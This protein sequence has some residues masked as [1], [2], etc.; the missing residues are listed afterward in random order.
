MKKIQ[1]LSVLVTILLFFF[2]NKISAQHRPDMAT[3]KQQM[4]RAQYMID[5]AKKANPEIQAALNKYGKMQ[6]DVQNQLDSFHKANPKNIDKVKMPTADELTK[7]TPLPDF[8]KIAKITETSNAQI[9]KY[10]ALTAQN[11]TEGLPKP[12]AGNNFTAIPD[13]DNN[14]IVAIAT[15]MQKVC[16]DSLNRINPYF[17]QALDT[18]ALDTTSTTAAKGMLMI[19]EG[20]SKFASKYL[21]CKG[22]VENHNNPW[23]IND[24]GT[25]LRNDN[26]LPE[27]IRCFKY[28]F[29]FNDTFQIIKC[30]MAWATAYYGDF[31]NA[32]KMFREIVQRI[33]SF[34]LA[35]EGLGMVAYKQGDLATVWECMKAQLKTF[36]GGDNSGPS[37][38][39]TSICDNVMQEQ[40]MKK[41]DGQG[42]QTSPMNDNTFTNDNGEGDDN[43][44]PPPTADSE[45][46]IYEESLGGMFAQNIDQMQPIN[47]QLKSF[48]DKILGKIKSAKD[49]VTEAQK[50]LSR[51]EPPAYTTDQGE[52]ITPHSF[53]KLNV[54][55]HIVQKQYSQRISWIHKGFEKEW[56]DLENSLTAQRIAFDENSTKAL[57]KCRSDQ[58]V[59]DFY[60]IWG[61]KAKGF[62]GQN[63]MGVS[64]LWSDYFKKVTNTSDWYVS[65][66]T[67]FIKRM[68]KQ[69]WNKYLNA[70]REDD[71]RNSILGF[72][73]KWLPMQ[74]LATDGIAVQIMSVEVSCQTEIREIPANGPDPKMV[75]LKKL[76]TAAPYCDRKAPGTSIDAVLF[77]YEDNCDH[78]K[79][80]F[81]PPHPFKF[82]STIGA[83][84]VK[85][86]VKVGVDIGFA[87]EEVK[88]PKFSDKNYYKAGIIIGVG[89]EASG[90]FKVGNGVSNMG[91]EGKMGALATIEFGSRYNQDLSKQGNYSAVSLS[92]GISGKLNL[93]GIK[94][95][96][97]S[98]SEYKKE[99]YTGQSSNYKVMSDGVTNTIKNGLQ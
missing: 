25:F 57:S 51:L 38:E 65:A 72:Y 98:K 44:D 6:P 61:P 91:G 84:P 97:S 31:I 35:W 33:P 28:A 13:A 83:G 52:T 92:E 37:D 10:R 67:P 48:Y 95:E 74:G 50:G 90:S 89:A 64:K 99:V 66:T 53:K 36:S 85:G 81:K 56:K 14:A 73:A 27:A 12:N 1:L 11:I 79:F 45:S 26:R 96:L 75:K 43:Q 21:V 54:L 40:D 46:P 62:L 2:S 34:N 39:F 3:V 59:H 71:I 17:K 47:L 88:D 23:A 20:Y 41:I 87:L 7:K 8:E 19:G 86:G 16:I 80:V 93:G 29:S 9:Q 76:H 77:S 82:E 15:A 60:C 68:V 55:F 69:D 49:K 42:E 24:L 58:E 30:N 18:F 32:K 63:L 4:A 5:S 78:T 70:V 22:I 94:G